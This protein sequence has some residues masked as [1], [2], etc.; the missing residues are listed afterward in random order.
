MRRASA[1]SEAA[2]ARLIVVDALDEQAAGFYRR[3]G[4]VAPLD[5]PLRLLRRMRDVRGAST[6]PT[7]ESSLAEVAESIRAASAPVLIYGAGV[8]RAQGWQPAVA[9][10]EAIN[11][12]L[13]IP[14]SSLVPP[15]I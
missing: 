12:V 7:A 3:H 4:F 2:G 8:A 14:I 15:L 5:N 11:T 9:L 13:E 10:A 1:S 6:P